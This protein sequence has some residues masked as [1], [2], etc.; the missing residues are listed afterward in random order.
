MI[1]SFVRDSAVYGFAS[2]LVRGI[3]ILLV[4]IYTR[5]LAPADYGILDLLSVA[6][7]FVG[8]LVSLEIVQAVARF[9]PDPE[10]AADRGVIASTALWFSVLV[11]GLFALLVQAGA[12]QIAT[13][14]LDGP[15]REGVVRLAAVSIA[16][17]GVFYVAQSQLRWQLLAK[18]YAISSVVYAL[19][20]AAAAL[21]L[22]L[23]GAGL[24]GVFIGQICGAVV[25]L[26]VSL[27]LA[28]PIYR[29]QI[30]SATLRDMLSFSLPLVPSSVGVYLTLYIDRIVINSVLGVAEV[31]IFGIGYRLAAL[32]TLVSVGVQGALSPL[33]YTH[34]AAERTRTDLARIFGAYVAL[35]LVVA[36]GLGIYAPEIIGLATTAAYERSA[37]VV[38]L[39]APALLVSGMYIFMPGAS[40]ERRTSLIAMTNFATAGLNTVLNVVLV[41][42]AGIVGAAAAT[43]TSAVAGFLLSAIISQRFYPV[44]HRWGPI[45][46][47]VAGM[48]VLMVIGVGLPAGTVFGLAAKSGLLLAA[49]AM[50]FAG[51]LISISDVVALRAAVQSVISRARGRV[52]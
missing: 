4:P 30:R 40:I 17:N 48:A 37:S 34:H 13:S 20:S 42:R 10:Y 19:V 27:R 12:A 8:V 9:F 22:I 5:F 50:C 24:V 26:V 25:G 29:L 14:L 41:P 16:L 31:G 6:A 49:V 18:R 32:V 46:I 23:G 3:G 11:Y 28:G 1:R 43:L 2:I 44:S 15:Q 36:L 35:S 45:A 39:L 33:I 47:C 52:G 38:P 7:S 21:T 51:G